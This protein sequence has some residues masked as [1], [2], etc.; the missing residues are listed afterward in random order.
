MF[1][2]NKVLDVIND[3]KGNNQLWMTNSG[4]YS[5]QFWKLTKDND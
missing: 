2:K 1:T 3:G 5:G 4:Y